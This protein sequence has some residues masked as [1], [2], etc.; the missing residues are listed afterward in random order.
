MSIV[1]VVNDVAD[2][3]RRKLRNLRVLIVNDYADT[4]ISQIISQSFF[5]TL[6]CS[7]GA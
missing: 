4:K 7:Q 6:A 1:H 2:T 5:T 3:R